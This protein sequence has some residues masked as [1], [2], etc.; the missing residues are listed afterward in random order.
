MLLVIVALAG[1]HAVQVRPPYEQWLT[2]LPLR[3][4]VGDPTAWPA[5]VWTADATTRGAVTEHRD[6]RIDGRYVRVY[7]DWRHGRFAAIYACWEGASVREPAAD[8]A[9]GSRSCTR[10]DRPAGAPLR[11]RR[12]AARG[13]WIV[14]YGGRYGGA[15]FTDRGARVGPTYASIL[16][17][18]APPASWVVAAWVAALIAV[19]L[20]RWPRARLD[21]AA[22]LASPY[23][24]GPTV[25]DAAD[26]ARLREAFALTICTLH[27]APLAAFFLRATLG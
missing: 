7:R 27:A 16:S 18:A 4:D 10:P 11:V 14:D 12:D 1:T 26:P 8:R 6:V 9:I 3:A 15:A 25:A 5:E 13:L 24:A 23:R 17:S 2:S 21:P 20:L 22:P 19:A